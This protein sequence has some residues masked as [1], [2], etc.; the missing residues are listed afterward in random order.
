MKKQGHLDAILKTSQSF[1]HSINPCQSGSQSGACPKTTELEAGMHFEWNAIPKHGTIHT[2]SHTYSY[3]W[4]ISLSQ[5][6]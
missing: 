2:F 6:P 5:S 3:L 4:E 1:I